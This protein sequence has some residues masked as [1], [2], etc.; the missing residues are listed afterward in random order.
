V[1][2]ERLLA[3]ALVRWVLSQYLPGTGPQQ[4]QFTRNSNGKPHLV[5]RLPGTQQEL[6]FNLSHTPDLLGEFTPWMGRDCSHYH[7][8]CVW[9]QLDARQLVVT[10]CCLSLG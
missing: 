8:F 2:H 7:V 10:V 1:A 3:R 5:Q 4:L 9:L 6:H